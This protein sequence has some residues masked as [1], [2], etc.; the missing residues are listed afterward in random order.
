MEI[1][2]IHTQIV[3]HLH[4]NKTNFHLKGFALGLALKQRRKGTR[5]SPITLIGLTISNKVMK[6]QNSTEYEGIWGYSLVQYN[7]FLTRAYV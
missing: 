1:S 4:V 2:F 6:L 3:V 5:K 7:R